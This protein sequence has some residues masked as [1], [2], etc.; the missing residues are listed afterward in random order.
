MSPHDQLAGI[1]PKNSMAASPSMTTFA[2]D[3]ASTI[4]HYGITFP[5]D[6]LHC[7]YTPTL[8]Q[9]RHHHSNRHPLILQPM[10]PRSCINPQWWLRPS[11]LHPSFFLASLPPKHRP[12]P[13]PVIMPAASPHQPLPRHTPILV[14]HFMATRLRPFRYYIS[15]EKQCASNSC[16]SIIMPTL[17]HLMGFQFP[18]LP[19]APLMGPWWA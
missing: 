3:V 7:S 2:H 11:Q 5:C 12:H 4:P 17:L 15:F 8:G 1:V 19:Q 16:S 9:G 10:H 6:P 18:Y 13:S 14:S